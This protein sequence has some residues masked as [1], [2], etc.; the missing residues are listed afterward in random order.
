MQERL[1]W[2]QKIIANWRTPKPVCPDTQAESLNFLHGDEGKYSVGYGVYEEP[3]FGAS[4]GTV[5]V[6]DPNKGT[7]A[8]LNNIPANDVAFAQAYL[9]AGGEGARQA[10]IELQGKRVIGGDEIFGKAPVPDDPDQ[11]EWPI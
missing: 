2:I 3:A 8:G 7:G 10:L 9:E 6:S 5:Y 11:P 4:T 1:N